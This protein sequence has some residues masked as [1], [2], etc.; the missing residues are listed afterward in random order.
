MIGFFK[1]KK[2]AFNVPL[3]LSLKEQKEVERII[4]KASKN[5]GVPRTAQ[6]SIPFD[7]MFQ[8]GIC[9]IGTDYYTKRF[10]SRTSTTSW[11]SRMIRAKYSRNG[12]HF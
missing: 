5:D 4:A 7:R 10:S 9:R 11:R 12:V 3:G 8:D 2:N 1:K 6:Q